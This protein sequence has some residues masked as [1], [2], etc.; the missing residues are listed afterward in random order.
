LIGVLAG[1]ES[2]LDLTPALMQ[3][4]RIQGVIVGHRACFEDMNRAIAAHAMK[5]VVDKVFPFADARAAFALMAE[6]GHF[7]KICVSVNG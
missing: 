6:G 5:P 4:V 7:G 3:D 2:A 1:R